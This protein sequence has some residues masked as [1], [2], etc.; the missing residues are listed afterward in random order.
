M[1]E[2]YHL[3]RIR[4]Q[5][6]GHLT[7]K[8]LRSLPERKRLH[9]FKLMVRTVCE[10]HHAR[11]Q[12]VFWAL[13]EEHG[14]RKDLSPHFHFLIAA[15]PGHIDLTRFS[16]DC[17][18]AWRADGGGLCEVTPYDRTLDGAAYIAKCPDNDSGPAGSDCGLM[19]SDA[20]WAY[21]RRVILRERG[22]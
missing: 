16:L 1:P 19:F 2:A 18:A 3:H 4:W 20:A 8:Q 22:I 12:K 14:T 9:R 5:I 7:F 17:A 13:R 11:Y 15:L 21:L 6:M 10:L